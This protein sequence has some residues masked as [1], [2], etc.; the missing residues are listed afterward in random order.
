MLFIE[1][2]CLLEV[3]QPI[4]RNQMTFGRKSNSNV[5]DRN[6]LP[7]DSKSRPNVDRNLSSF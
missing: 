1:I 5:V 2:K 4:D 3:N 7:F 6:Q